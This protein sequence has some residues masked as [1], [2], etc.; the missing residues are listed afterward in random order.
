MTQGRRRRRVGGG[1]I[2]RGRRGQRGH[3]ERGQRCG[4]WRRTRRSRS[5]RPR[6]T[7]AT[8]GT[9]AARPIRR[10]ATDIGDAAATSFTVTHN[11]G[12]RDVVVH[13]Q[14]ESGGSFRVVIPDVSMPTVNTVQLDFSVAPTSAQYRV[15]VNG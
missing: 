12:T 10:F 11:L 6:L 14:G 2:G 13:G 15:V 1:R 8:L 7:F 3:R 4:C 9:R 5:A